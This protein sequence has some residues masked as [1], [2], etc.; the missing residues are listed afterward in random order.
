MILILAFLLSFPLTPP[1]PGSLCTPSDPDFLEYRYPE[2][3]AYC[4]RNVT[5]WR[6]IEICKRDGVYDRR[7]YTVD[8]IISLSVGGSNH[9]DN[10]WCQHEDLAVT[11]LEYRMFRK[12]SRGD[13]SQVEAIDTILDAKFKF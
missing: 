10:L 7:H 6:K 13:I 12:L 3:I 2:R 5:T 4:R 8:H 9:D 1:V 11:D